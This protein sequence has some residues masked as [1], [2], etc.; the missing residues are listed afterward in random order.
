MTI[1]SVPLTDQP[2]IRAVPLFATA[3]SADGAESDLS[4][5]QRLK[6]GDQTA[7]DPLFRRHAPALVSLAA[8][9]TGS[10]DDGKDVVQD[11]FERLAITAVGYREQAE[12]AAWL[13]GVT[14][15]SALNARRRRSRRRET[16][17]IALDIV[18]DRADIA[19]ALDLSNAVDTLAL[20]LR[21]VFL[22]KVVAGYSHQE[23]AEL[24]GIRSGTSE[25][26]L[27]RAIRQLRTLLSERP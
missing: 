21:D 10:V 23:V 24:L 1:A 14:S 17:E 18:R 11:V 8:R 5:I 27:F 26:R 3:P 16:T 4:L 15:K 19:G 13:R 2:L 12:A 20:P 7:L 25:V 6:R 9:I 22:L